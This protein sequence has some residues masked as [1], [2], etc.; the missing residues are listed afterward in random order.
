MQKEWTPSGK[1]SMTGPL[2]A[3]AGRVAVLKESLTPQGKGSQSRLDTT[4][5]Q[6]GI[7]LDFVGAPKEGS[8]VIGRN[9]LR[10]SGEGVDLP[11]EKRASH[12]LGQ[13]REAERGG[14]HGVVITLFEQAVEAHAQV[15]RQIPFSKYSPV[16]CIDYSWGYGPTAQ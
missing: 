16:L 9:Q 10:A 15:C 5:P 6:G 7:K 14:N 12:W 3:L 4:T 1:A 13:I 8:F 2:E 11:E